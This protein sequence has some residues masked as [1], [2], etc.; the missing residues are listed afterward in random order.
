VP[1]RKNNV[2]FNFLKK[3]K[4]P[5][6]YKML[7]KDCDI[8]FETENPQK[9]ACPICGRSKRVEVFSIVNKETGEETR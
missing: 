4:D 6:K 9:R 7:C 3:E 1:N 5:Y 2:M 8:F